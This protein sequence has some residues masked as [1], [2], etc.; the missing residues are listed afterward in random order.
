MNQNTTK[1]ADLRTR[2]GGNTRRIIL[3]AA[4]EIFLE[5]GYANANVDKISKKAKV[6]YGTV[7]SHFREG[8]PEILNGVV[9]H[10][11]DEFQNQLKILKHKP[12]IHGPKTAEYI[13]KK[14]YE[15]TIGIFR[16]AA[17]NRAFLRIV[18]EGKGEAELIRRFWI[19]QQELFVEEFEKQVKNN[20]ELGLAVKLDAH[21][22]SIGY[23]HLIWNY[24]WN[25]ILENENIDLD[26]IAK[27]LVE[28][29]MWGVYS[30]DGHSKSVRYIQGTE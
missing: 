30:Q 18:Q 8:K 14:L 15:E 11:S 22:I 29:Y 10:I 19:M 9:K 7:Y 21:I 2:R 17:K 24:V 6:G 26:K 25:D 20:Q 12:N 1:I 3:E 23:I 28:F 13:E 4:R 27:N 5:E 16:V